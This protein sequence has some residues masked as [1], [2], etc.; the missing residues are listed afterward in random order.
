MLAKDSKKVWLYPAIASVVGLGMIAVVLSRFELSIQF[1]PVESVPTNSA[2][3]SDPALLPNEAD[4]PRMSEAIAPPFP[5]AEVDQFLVPPTQMPSDASPISTIRV[6]NRSIHPVRIALL[7]AADTDPVHWD[8]APAEGSVNGLLLS[9]PDQDLNVKPGD[10][11]VAFAQDGSR[12]YWGPY[13]VGETLKPSWH[14]ETGEWYL[15]LT[16]N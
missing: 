7:S 4:A 2:D 13:I 16:E 6:S 14:R 9:L 1:E 3:R 5:E 15:I 8:F 10:I 11:V 12:Q